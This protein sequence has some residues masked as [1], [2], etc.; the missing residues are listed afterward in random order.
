M[1]TDLYRF[2]SAFSVCF[3]G[4]LFLYL[5]HPRLHNIFG[6]SPQPVVVWL[7]MMRARWSR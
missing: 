3:R 4:W 5:A 1:N 7:S 2:A 6:F